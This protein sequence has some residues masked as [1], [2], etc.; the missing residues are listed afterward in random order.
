MA[1]QKK[2]T[3]GSEAGGD[4]RSVLTD[5]VAAMYRYGHE[6]GDGDIPSA[7]RNLLSRA[8]QFLAKPSS[9]AGSRV[10]Q[11]LR[12]RIDELLTE[13][14]FLTSVISK[15]HEPHCALWSDE[16]ADCDCR[17]SSPAGGDVQKAATW[18]K[19]FLSRGVDDL[20]NGEIDDLLRM[21]AALSPSTSAAEPVRGEL[22]IWKEGWIAERLSAAMHAYLAE[23]VWSPDE[24]CDHE[25]TE[26]ERM[27]M[28]DMLN[29]A[30]SAKPVE[31]L[32]QDAAFAMVAAHPAPAAVESAQVED[33]SEA[34]KRDLE[35]AALVV[36]AR[37]NIPPDIQELLIAGDP[38]RSVPPGLLKRLVC[39]ARRASL[40]TEKEG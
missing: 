10:E 19:Y 20:G 4:W 25:P 31:N 7:H 3:S 2:A 37:S 23:Y 17:P 18:A 26:F 22:P 32:L 16:P 13:R 14:E 6:I 11:D 35:V 40:A 27:I 12:A 5:M 21:V 28:E 34:E 30:L 33:L 9:P 39:D 15:S 38:H 36:L 1:E 29:G 8:E 24:G